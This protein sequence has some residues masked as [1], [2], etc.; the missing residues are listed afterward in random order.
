VNVFV[1]A[2][3]LDHLGIEILADLGENR[4]QVM[5]CPFGKHVAQKARRAGIW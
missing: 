2:V 3:A 4:P 5:D 1:F